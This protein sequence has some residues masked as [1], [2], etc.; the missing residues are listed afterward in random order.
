M[1][2]LVRS[3]IVRYSTTFIYTYLY[4]RSLS[5]AMTAHCL[6]VKDRRCHTLITE[7]HLPWGI[8]PVVI[9]LLLYS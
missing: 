5:H 7:L 9:R 4:A 3:Q 1:G 8:L 2:N 6:L